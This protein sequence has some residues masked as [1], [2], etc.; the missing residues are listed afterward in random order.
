MFPY[1]KRKNKAWNDTQNFF[2]EALSVATD[3]WHSSQL[4]HSLQSLNYMQILTVNCL[5]H[6]PLKQ[7][8][9]VKWESL[10]ALPQLTCPPPFCFLGQK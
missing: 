4:S 5:A 3:S 8:K 6:T 7:K 2:L 10:H 1:Q 9:S